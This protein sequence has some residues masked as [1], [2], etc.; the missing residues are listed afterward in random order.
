MDQRPAELIAYRRESVAHQARTLSALSEAAKAQ[1]TCGEEARLAQ[2]R[3]ARLSEA[4]AAALFQSHE[5]RQA[6]TQLAKL[7]EEL[8]GQGHRAAVLAERREHTALLYERAP[9]GIAQSMQVE[10]V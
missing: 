4:H 8:A 5:V 7:Q 9:V 3:R 2:L 1:V 10:V 6:R